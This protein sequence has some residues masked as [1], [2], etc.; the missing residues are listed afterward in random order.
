MD[1]LNEAELRYYCDLF[2]I[3]SEQS[4]SSGKIPALQ[5]TKLFRSANL[6][7]EIL[8]KVSTRTISLTLLPRMCTCC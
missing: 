6:S 3:C 4:D 7:N 5:A 2:K 8:N 1:G